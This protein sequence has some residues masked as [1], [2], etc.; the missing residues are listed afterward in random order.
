M[1]L[2]PVP[3]RH[4][5]HEKDVIRHFDPG[6]LILDKG[7]SAV[8]VVYLVS[9]SAGVVLKNNDNESIVVD[10]R[11]PGDIFGGIEFFTGV[12][13][14]SDAELIADEPVKALDMSVEDFEKIGR[15]HV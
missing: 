9:G 4:L 2:I 1:D 15:A 11:G 8:R 14:Q 3:L 10:S 7:T 6:D 13:W 12:P 5:A